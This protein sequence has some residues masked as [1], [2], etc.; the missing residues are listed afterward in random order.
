MVRVAVP[1]GIVIMLTGG[2]L[3]ISESAHSRSLKVLTFWGV[4]TR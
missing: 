4:N 2:V 3:A 1:R